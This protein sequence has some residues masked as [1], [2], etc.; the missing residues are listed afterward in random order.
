MSA[1]KHLLVLSALLIC[2][3][4]V[5]A[6]AAESPAVHPAIQ[7]AVDSQERLPKDRSRDA[8]RHYAEL[9]EFFGV[10]P[11]MTV[12]ELFA[13]GGNTAEVLARAVG[14]TG[15]VYMQNP[16]WFYER[17][18][19]S[20]QKPVEERLANGRLPNVVRLDKPLNDLGLEPE[21]LDGAVAFMVLHDFFWLSQ[22][23]PDVLADVHKAL[24]PGGWFAVVD[25]SAPTGTGIEQ[26]KD[27]DN[28]THRIEEASV[29]KLFADAGFVLAA[30]NDVLRNPADDRSKPFFDESFKGKSTDRFVL[31]F[32]KK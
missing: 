10:R 23:V 4:M 3:V 15:K 1:S 28:G 22:D 32:V 11:G 30:N 7:A 18:A 8:N 9:L 13:A 2:S 5:A 24:K 29:K 16:E 14:P 25:H 6:H 12:I 27:R 26:A 31:K 21:S 17:V 20:G 19:K